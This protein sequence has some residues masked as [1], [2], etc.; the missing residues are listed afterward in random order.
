MSK[1]KSKLLYLEHLLLKKLISEQDTSSNTEQSSG[2]DIE[3]RIINAMKFNKRRKPNPGIP[4]CKFFYTPPSDPEGGAIGYRD[5]EI[6]ALGTNR[7]G[8]RVI[9]GWIKSDLSKTLKRNRPNDRI[10]WRM[11]RLDGISGF[12]YTIQNFDIS[13]SFLASN[14]PKLNKLFNKALTDV[15]T[16]FDLNKKK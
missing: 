6:F 13:D 10:R 4:V 14:R 15:T 3:T 9:Y 7:W 5:V 12:K 2:L 8:N 1:I 16:V 11:F